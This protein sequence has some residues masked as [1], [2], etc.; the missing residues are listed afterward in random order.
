MKVCFCD[1]ST[2]QCQSSSTPRLLASSE[3]QATTCGTVKHPTEVMVWLVISVKGTGR[4]HIVEGNMNADQY[5][6]VLTPRLVPSLH[7]W[8][9][10]S[11]NTELAIRWPCHKTKKS[12]ECLRRNNIAVVNWPGNS[13][14]CNTIKTLWGI[15]K[16]RVRTQTDD[17]ARAYFVDHQSMDKR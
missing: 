2:F 15:T 8:R 5:V 3:G 11:C 4:L 1:E 16:R 9:F 6:H 17:Q 7:H 13:H 12:M 10:V 14:D